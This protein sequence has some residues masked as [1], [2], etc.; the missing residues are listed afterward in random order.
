MSAHL[1]IA[2]LRRGSGSLALPFPYTLE[3][4]ATR[5]MSPTAAAT[6]F[7]FSFRAVLVLIAARWFNWGTEPGVIAGI[8]IEVMLLLTAAMRAF[9]P[10]TRPVAWIFRMPCIRWVLLFLAFSCCSLAWSGTA[11][12]VASFMYWATMAADVL[13]ILLL[14]RSEPATD[15]AHSVM[16]GYVVASVIL[17]V[18]AWLL[19][20]APDLRLGDPEYFNTNQIGNVCAMGVFMAQFLASRKDGRWRVSVLFLMLTL[21]RSLSKAT[22]IAFVVSQGVMLIQNNSMTRSR[23]VAIAISALALGLIFG[24]FFQSYL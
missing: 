9:G 2:L 1:P 7:L 10:A 23:K 17:A 11:S 18:V 3:R 19:P 6:G 22:L 16:K 12:P 4:A 13:I 15:V 21:V 14:L 8:I 20:V 5:Q 24:G